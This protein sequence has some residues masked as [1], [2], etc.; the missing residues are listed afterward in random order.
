MRLLIV[1][2]EVKKS[3][4]SSSDDCRYQ[5]NTQSSSALQYKLFLLR[6]YNISSVIFLPTSNVNGFG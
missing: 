4:V 2:D 3:T 6:Q 5:F 1:I